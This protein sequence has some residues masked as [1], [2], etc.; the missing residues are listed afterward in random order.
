[1]PGN[2]KRV[3]GSRKV[4]MWVRCGMEADGGKVR[5]R[6]EHWQTGEKVIVQVGLTHG[7]FETCGM[8]VVA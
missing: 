8:P 1:M 4:P 7:M 2:L 3:G 5:C 6:L